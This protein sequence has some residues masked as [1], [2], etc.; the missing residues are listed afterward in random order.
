MIEQ[1]QEIETRFKEGLHFRSAVCSFL[2]FAFGT[3]ANIMF[4]T[5]KLSKACHDPGIKDYEAL[6]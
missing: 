1:Q 2:Y 4:I 5:C 3:R 6:L